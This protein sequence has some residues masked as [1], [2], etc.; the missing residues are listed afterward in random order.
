MLLSNSI[1]NNLKKTFDSHLR[2]LSLLVGISLASYRQ[3]VDHLFF[4]VYQYSRSQVKIHRKLKNVSGIEVVNS[5]KNKSL[6]LRSINK[7]IALVSF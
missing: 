7:V 5:K 6:D 4:Q 2:F 1:T 3:H